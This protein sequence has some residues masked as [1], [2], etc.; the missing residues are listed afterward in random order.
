MFRCYEDLSDVKLGLDM[1]LQRDGTLPLI[2]YKL[3]IA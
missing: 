2:V 3:T 1:L